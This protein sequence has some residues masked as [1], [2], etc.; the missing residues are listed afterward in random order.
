[1][2]DPKTWCT[3]KPFGYRVAHHLVSFK[4]LFQNS[5]NSYSKYK[6]SSVKVKFDLTHFKCL[7]IYFRKINKYYFQFLL[8]ISFKFILKNYTF[9]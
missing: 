8:S 9:I 7:T 1:M 5:Y 4:P 3:K 6:I 2:F